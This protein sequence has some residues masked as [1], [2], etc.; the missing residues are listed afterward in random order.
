LTLLIN[1]HE[2]PTG[3]H[4]FTVSW[5][6]KCIIG[7]SREVGADGSLGP[8]FFRFLT[9]AELTEPA[10]YE[11]KLKFASIL[12]DWRDQFAIFIVGVAGL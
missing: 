2:S 7:T 9:I 3:K 1:Y 8:I 5:L 6:S 11:H 4:S 10:S 12:S